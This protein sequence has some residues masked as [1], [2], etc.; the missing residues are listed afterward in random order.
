[1]YD[2]Q[3]AYRI[4]AYKFIVYMQIQQQQQNR[5]KSKILEMSAYLYFI[6]I[7]MYIHT[8]IYYLCICV[9]VH[10]H[11]DYKCIIFQT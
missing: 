10:A 1:M 7:H 11:M 4:Y 6:C 2:M 8:Y 3:N 9:Y 5:W